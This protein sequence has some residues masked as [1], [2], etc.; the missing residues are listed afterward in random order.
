MKKTCIYK[1][2]G[3]L[4]TLLLLLAVYSINWIRIYIQF[5]DLIANLLDFIANPSRIR[6]N[7]GNLQRQTGGRGQTAID[8]IFGMTWL[9]E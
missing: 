2:K 6:F 3:I 9:R 1:F 4:W 5:K 7:S 8:G